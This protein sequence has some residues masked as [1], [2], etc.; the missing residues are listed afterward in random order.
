MWTDNLRRSYLVVD[1]QV[2]VSGRRTRQGK[3]LRASCGKHRERRQRRP[4]GTWLLCLPTRRPYLSGWADAR[5]GTGGRTT[6]G[7]L[8]WKDQLNSLVP[9]RHHIAGHHLPAPSQ[10]NLAVDDD[11]PLGK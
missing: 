7:I 11:A 8:P 9:A 3:P 5:G 4:R 10:L 2:S 1:L 6:S